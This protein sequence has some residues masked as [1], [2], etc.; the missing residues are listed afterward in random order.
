M[1]ILSI[2]IYFLLYK[3]TYISKSI[4]FFKTKDVFIYI[5]RLLKLT[6]FI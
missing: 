6:S 3:K 4:N 1:E 5:V 2:N